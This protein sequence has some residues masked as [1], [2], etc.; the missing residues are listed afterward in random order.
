M[1]RRLA[2]ICVCVVSTAAAAADLDAPQ[3]A[4]L[5]AEIEQVAGQVNNARADI[6]LVEKQY[7][8]RE[9]PSDE[10]ARLARYAD[11]ELQHALENYPGAATLFYD[12]VADKDFHK[13]KMYGEALFYLADSLYQ[14]KNFLGARLYLRQLLALKGP[15]YREGLARYLEIAGRMNEFVGI[16]EYINQARG[17]SGGELPPELSY[18]YAKWMFRREDLSPEDRVKK[19]MGTFKMLAD[20]QGGALWLQAA[21]FLGVGHVKLKEYDLA[22]A[23]FERVAA[24]KP[25]GDREAQVKELAN[26]SLG[27]VLYEMGQ[28]D[29][30]IDRYQEIPLTSPNFVDAMYETAWTYVKKGELQR[31]RNTVEILI[32]VSK[33][34]VVEPEARIL[35]GT[36]LLKLQ[37]YEEATESYEQVINI[38]APVRDEI[39]ALLTVNKDPVKYFDDLL[40]RN[41]KTLDVAALLPPIALKWASTRR[42]VG[43]AV[44]VINQLEAGRRGVTESQDIANRIL[45]VLDERGTEAFPLLQAGVTRADAVDNSVTR[46]EQTLTRI[47]GQLAQA[48]LSGD[49]AAELAKARQ[50]ADALKARIDTLPT[51]E[52]EVQARKKRMQEKI[53]ALRQDVFRAG[54]DAQSA[55]AQL[56]AITKF[57]DDTRAQRK[58]TPEDEKAFVERVQTER[59]GIE[60]TITDL[61]Q[62]DLRLRDEGTNAIAAISGEDQLKKDYAALLDK[63]KNLFRDAKDKLPGQARQALLRCDVIRADATAVRERVASAKATL[64]DRVARRSEKFRATIQGEQALLEGYGQ[65]VA[66]VSGNARDLV[67]RIAFDSFRR[68][69]QQ[70]YDLVLKADVGV[71]DVAFTRKQ[72]KTVS[73]QKLSA[74]KDRELKALDEE[75]KEVLKDVD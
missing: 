2:S 19:A 11:A 26:L 7:S 69:R 60:A 53:E 41:D 47:E 62:L 9:E 68:V 73:I 45:R 23:A 28:F 40:S 24:A 27:R 21:Y 65:E 48:Y 13:S 51:T 17:L 55:V 57:V 20:N 75:F 42:E 67:G 39:D 10:A 29:K 64:R 25:R 35:Q 70:F 54:L 31:A 56:T 22:V 50:E 14:Q 5:E 33:D 32:M 8:Q 3:M 34:S 74:Q 12:L 38:Y 36:L 18:V 58:D 15:H 44:E 59:R 4:Q 43:D 66:S 6:N 49:Q 72:D 30:A 1:S 46:A 63:Q 52:A 37:K 61:D 16:D 71:I